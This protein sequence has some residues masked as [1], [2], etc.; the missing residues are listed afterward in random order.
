MPGCRTSLAGTQSS[1]DP[2]LGCPCPSISVAG[3]DPEVSWHLRQRRQTR[4]SA[5]TW[6]LAA[7][8]P[9]PDY[10]IVHAAPCRTITGRPTSGETWTDQYIKIRADT[11]QE[12]DDWAQLKTG[13]RGAASA[14]PPD[15]GSRRMQRTNHF[16]RSKG[17]RA[18]SCRT[19]AHR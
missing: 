18:G 16:A 13:T 5:I 7:R 8:R 11:I 15:G 1:S 12:L 3:Q 10:L 6:S 14:I 19:M 9:T 17:S 4:G 2:S